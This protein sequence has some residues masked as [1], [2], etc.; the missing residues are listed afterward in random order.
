MKETRITKLFGINY[1]I[2]QGGMVWCSGWKLASAVSNCGGLGLIGIGSMHPETFEEH[3]L[4]M[5]K[6]TNKPWGVNIP[7]F[8]PELDKI[9]EL[10]FKHEIKIVFTSAGSPNILTKRFKDKGVTVVHVVANSYFANKCEKA[11]VDAIV[12]E[13]FEAGGHNS[14]LET[15]SLVLLQDVLKK[16]SIPIIAAGGIGSGRAILACR[17]L[18]AE[19]VQIGSL[20]ASSEESSAHIKYKKKIAETGEGGTILDLKEISPTR[21]IP[22]AFTKEMNSLRESCA[23]KDEMKKLLG[24]GR[25]KKGIFEGD[26]NEG[27]IEIGQ[28][29]ST[30]NSIISVKDIFEHLICEYDSELL[31]LKQ[32]L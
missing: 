10:I 22:N 32:E 18:G 11:G 8:Y 15:T 25:A 24:R 26:L 27:E 17:C 16:V 1:P 19:G 13:G 29:A 5:K 2:I 3:I 20:F 14:P 7:L 9:V 31:I 28:I 30:I 12:V 4:N 23:S 21:L 6:A